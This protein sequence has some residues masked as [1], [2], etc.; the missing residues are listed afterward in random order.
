ME[1]L[2]NK[3]SI[4]GTFGDDEVINT[5]SVDILDTGN[6]M[7]KLGDRIFGDI[8][9]EI[10]YTISILTGDTVP[11]DLALADVP[12]EGLSFIEGSLTLDG[13]AKTG[14]V[15]DLVIDFEPNT[16]Y[17]VKYRAVK[18][19]KGNLQNR[20]TLTG[21][22]CGDVTTISGLWVLKDTG[23]TIDKSS[24]RDYAEVGTSVIFTVNITIGDECPDDLAFVDE[25]EE[26]LQ[27]IEGTIRVNDVHYPDA[28]LDNLPIN[29]EPNTT[30]TITYMVEK[31]ATGE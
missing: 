11:D 15:N 23:V 25:M 31:V 14:G 7:V 28:T 4:T 18:T 26:G 3:A 27:F 20:A 30:Y 17:V 24:N 29:F 16:S 10:E 6:F 8:G 1:T 2:T 5:S 21:T 12:A 9:T 19:K 22:Y 13:V